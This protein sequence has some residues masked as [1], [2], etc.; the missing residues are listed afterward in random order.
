MLQA[1]LQLSANASMRCGHSARGRGGAGENR[2][3]RYMVLMIVVFWGGLAT[4]DY[5]F[6]HGHHTRVILHA[7][8]W[9]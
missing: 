1:Y 3:M 4:L 9:W 7:L 6:N 5:L 2:R 8:G